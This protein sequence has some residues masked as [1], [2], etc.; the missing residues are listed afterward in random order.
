M[1]GRL[2]DLVWV[3]DGGVVVVWVSTTVID[4]EI[5]EV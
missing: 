3:V 4:D 1:E 5:V 2:V